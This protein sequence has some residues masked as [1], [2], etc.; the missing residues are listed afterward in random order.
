MN[1]KKG[2]GI[3]L[4]LRIAQAK[5]E[6]GAPDAAIWTA[7]AEKEAIRLGFCPKCGRLCAHVP[8]F[9]VDRPFPSQ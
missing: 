7:R 5:R 2:N 9:G 1:V 3:P 6:H 8:P 4:A